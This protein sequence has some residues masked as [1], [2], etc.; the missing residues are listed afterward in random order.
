MPGGGKDCI[1]AV[2]VVDEYAITLSPLRHALRR[3]DRQPLEGADSVVV[4]AGPGS[5][6]FQRR[7][8]IYG[9][10]HQQRI[11]APARRRPVQVVEGRILAERQI[12]ATVL[13][14]ELQ[15]LERR[16]FRRA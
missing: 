7:P 15:L 8:M 9:E 16:V 12:R 14:E 2:L 10:R 3:L 11:V 4:G 1:A 6:I 13:E 5:N